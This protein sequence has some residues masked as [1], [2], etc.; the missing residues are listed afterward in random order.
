MPYF[1][2]VT[3]EIRVIRIKV[4]FKSNNIF[5]KIAEKVRLNLNLLVLSIT[6]KCNYCLFI[7]SLGYE[8]FEFDAS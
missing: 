4:Q 8:T 7:T 6:L 3:I 1:I 2:C 5:I